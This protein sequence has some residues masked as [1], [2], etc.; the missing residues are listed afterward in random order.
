LKP[1]VS[2]NDEPAMLSA[3]AFESTFEDG[4][5]IVF[6]CNEGLWECEVETQKWNPCF[7]GQRFNAEQKKRAKIVY[8]LHCL[9]NH[10]SD[11]VLWSLLTTGSLLKCELTAKDVRIAA[12]INGPCR[13]CLAGKMP[14]AA[15]P[16][17]STT[18]QHK[19]I[20]SDRDH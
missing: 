9:L 17:S 14:D 18:Q 6:N 16:A 12:S 4:K 20:R 8:D 13:H 7:T 5:K 1:S 2:T 10:P 3:A 19:L 15:A 11:D